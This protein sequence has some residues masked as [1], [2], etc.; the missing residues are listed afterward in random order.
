MKI[1]F[2]H[3]TSLAFL[4]LVGC[5]END[6]GV[7]VVDAAAD[8]PAGTGGIGSPFDG[9]AGG[10]TVPS[11]GGTIGGTGGAVAGTGG[12]VASTGDAGSTEPCGAATCLTA[13]FQTCVPDGS[14]VQ[15]GGGSPSAVF[16]DTCYANGVNVFTQ[17]SY[18]GSYVSVQ[19][20]GLGCYT[21]KWRSE[22]N[23]SAVSYTIIDGTGQ[24]I[25]TAVTADKEGNLTV[26][27]KGG[28][29]TTVSGACLDAPRGSATCVPGECPP[30][31]GQDAGIAD[32]GI[33]DAGSGCDPLAPVPKPITLGT[34]LGAGRSA[35]GTVYVADQVGSDYRVFVS[36]ANGTLVR[37]HVSGSGTTS[38]TSG[39]NYVI[40][41]SDPAAPFVL[42]I[43]APK[44]GD[45]RM[46]VLSGTLTD[47]KGFVIGQEG[48]EL[49]V[50]PASAIASMPLRNLPGTIVAEYIA[51]LPDGQLMLVTRP[52]DNWD[53]TDFR[54]FLG[55][56]DAVAERA[57]STVTRFR[58]GGSTQILFDLGGV[59]ATASFPVMLVDGS[60][61]P[62]PAT[63][64]VGGT[65]TP[66][67][68]RSTLPAATFTC[69]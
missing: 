34:V 23:A 5:S 41:V 67:T 36:D 40:S 60:F 1:R 63:L 56:T 14:C 59:Q 54:L 57:V 42:Q 10:T 7:G 18:L 69:R 17:G 30:S 64:T 47:R 50:L 21:I 48:E 68:R 38:S 43:D 3:L 46:G 33:A 37:Q 6:L 53:F 58:D 11:T 13:L 44:P 39:I 55:P 22:T 28:Q 52:A 65:T 35:G 2:H 4:V 66:L 24:E 49:T 26:T 29:P 12:V 20:A 8:H 61:A 31:A 45:M 9:G 15:Y 62:G 51:T 19:R 27:C 16:S 32:A 25:A